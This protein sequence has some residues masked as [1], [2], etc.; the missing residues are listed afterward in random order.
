[1]EG[2]QVLEVVGG[3][4]GGPAGVRLLFRVRVAK[5]AASVFGYQRARAVACFAQLVDDRPGGAPLE[6][7]PCPAAEPRRPA[8]PVDADARLRSALIAASHG[9]AVDEAAVRAAVT[10]LGLHSGTR[11]RPRRHR[12]RRGR[13]A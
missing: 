11:R 6:R 2:T 12:R 10:E 3:D 7:V 13:P 1:V 9:S 4:R 8:L 5:T